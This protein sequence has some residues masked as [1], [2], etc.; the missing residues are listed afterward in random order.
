VDSKLD[1][2][3]ML[4]ALLHHE[5][6]FI[7]VGGVAAALNGAPLTTFDLDVVHSREA[8]NVERLLAALEDLRARSR[9][10]GESEVKPDRSHLSSAGHQLLMT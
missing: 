10:H 5:V 8:G 9:L 1:F 7:V 3:A 4:R 2:L 6:D